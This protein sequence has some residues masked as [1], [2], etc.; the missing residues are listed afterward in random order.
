MVRK[1][2][3]LGSL[4]SRA[5]RVVPPSGFTTRLTQFTAAAMAFLAVFALALSLATGR[6]AERWSSELARAVTVRISAPADQMP[7]QTDA[8]VRVLETTPGVS[9]YRV[10]NEKDE[11]ALLEPWLGP[12]LP[13][14]SLPIPQL[15]EIMEDS[16]GINAE[17]LRLRL[18]AEA[19]GAI[20]DDHSRWRQP[21]VQAASRLRILGLLAITLITLATGAM[22]ALAAN[23]AL[24]ANRE[25]IRVL[26]LVGARDAF[27]VRAFVRRFTLRSLGGAVVGVILG[28]TAL[29]TLPGA[30][31]NAGFLTGLRF[32]GVEWFWLLLIP[33]VAALVA[34]LATRMAAFRALRE[35]T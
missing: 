26:R 9:S 2:E 4:Q 8:V 18:Q 24:A 29:F 3:F 28:A 1:P 35:F 13:L 15:I 30:D 19:P 6:L 16:T 20:L 27:I 7:A 31:E 5:D 32:Q 22:I 33:P 11:R 25:V 10:L 21:L 17:G 12:G 34:F 23:S 14:E